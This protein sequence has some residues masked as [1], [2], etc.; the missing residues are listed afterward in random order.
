MITTSARH[1]R[2]VTP[3]IRPAAGSAGRPEPRIGL[4][5]CSIWGVRAPDPQ[6]EIGQLSGES[7]AH[8][9][10]CR[11]IHVVADR[12][13]L[14]G[15]RQTMRDRPRAA[16]A[17][18]LHPV[19]A[20]SRLFICDAPVR[21]RAHARTFGIA[22][23]RPRRDGRPVRMLGLRELAHERT[24]PAPLCVA[25]TYPPPPRDPHPRASTP[26]PCRGV[27]DRHTERQKQAWRRVGCKICRHRRERAACRK[28]GRAGTN[29]PSGVANA[30]GRGA[31]SRTR[32]D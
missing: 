20:G 8:C 27:P 3:D 21:H 24:R 11:Q 18:R 7:D 1:A 26:I 9:Q 5:V 31:E 6:I 12:L 17:L 15:H 25:G 13:N 29:R 32:S 2:V 14:P 22:A 16:R 23:A 19:Y 10:F 4:I 30:P 28:T